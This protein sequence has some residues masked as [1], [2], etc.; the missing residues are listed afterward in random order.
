M[1]IGCIDHS[2]VQGW[3]AEQVRQLLQSATADPACAALNGMVDPGEVL[4]ASE[5]GL[6]PPIAATDQTLAGIWHEFDTTPEAAAQ[7]AAAQQ[8]G[9]PGGAGA[10]QEA[11]AQRAQSQQQPP[12]APPHTAGAEGVAA[13]GAAGPSSS[14][15]AAACQVST[16]GIVSWQPLLWFKFH[17]VEEATAFVQRYRPLIEQ[18]GAQAT[19]RHR[20][21]P[22]TR[23]GHVTAPLGEAAAQQPQQQQQQQQQQQPGAAADPQWLLG[24][25]QQ[26]A[27]HPPLHPQQPLPAQVALQAAQQAQQAHQ[28]QQQQQQQQ[29]PG[30]WQ[31]PQQQGMAGVIPAPQQEQGLAAAAAAAAAA[32]AADE[33]P[34]GPPPIIPLPPAMGQPVVASVALPAGAHVGLY[35]GEAPAG[36]AGGAQQPQQQQLQEDAEGDADSQSDDMDDDDTDTG[37]CALHAVLR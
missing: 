15:G 36:G 30:G 13:D 35:Y 23:R 20:G 5:A 27:M 8:Q 6:L 26:A 10:A 24:Q 19:L 12:L 14:G 11:A 9:A 32:V 7:Q 16:A 4:A 25:L 22:P 33:A 17:S 21:P 18:Y 31:Q 37:G 28:Q 1:L 29:A 2:R 3:S 34:A